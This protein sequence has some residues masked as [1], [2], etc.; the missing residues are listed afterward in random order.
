MK[1]YDFM[2]NYIIIHHL[3]HPNSSFQI[4]YTSGTP[5]HGFNEFIEGSIDNLM[6]IIKT[7]GLIDR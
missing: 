3:E 6:I 2:H 7:D 4:S 5:N 1:L